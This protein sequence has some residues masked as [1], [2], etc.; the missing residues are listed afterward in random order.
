LA[1]PKNNECGG[2]VE[3]RHALALQWRILYFR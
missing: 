3:P 2:S 1:P